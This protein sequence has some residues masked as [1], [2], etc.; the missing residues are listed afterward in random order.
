MHNSYAKVY[1]YVLTTISA[2]NL[3]FGLAYIFTKISALWAPLLISSLAEL[4][5]LIMSIIMIIKVFTKKLNKINLVI[6]IVYLF[7]AITLGTY[8]FIASP[9]TSNMS[10][11]DAYLYD[12][13][14]SVPYN[15]IVLSINMIFYVFLIGFSMYLLRNEEFFRQEK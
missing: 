3:I 15:L 9:D 8:D 1:L 4:I 2:A 13:D 10:L 6:P 12:F 14:I 11:K 7:T 5:V